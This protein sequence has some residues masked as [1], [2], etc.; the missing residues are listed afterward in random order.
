MKL[1]Q[2]KKDQLFVKEFL[3]RW[4]W[5]EVILVV[6]AAVVAY[7][8]LS[9]GEAEYT[10]WSK[11]LAANNV[12]AQSAGE[13]LRSVPE[14]S[15]DDIISGNSSA[16]AKLIVYIDFTCPFSAELFQTLKLAR[17]EHGD[18]LAI[19]WRMFPLAG[20][21]EA[22]PAARAF[23]CVAKQGYAYQMMEKL[24]AMQ[25]AG[26]FAP[27]L[28][29]QTA[30]NLGAK[31]QDYD[32]CITAKETAA[33]IMVQ[34]SEAEAAGVIGTPHTFTVYGNYPGALPME[35]FTDSLGVKRPGLKS[36]VDKLLE[37]K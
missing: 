9:G 6:A 13:P 32:E 23:I 28:Y 29:R 22:E 21:A 11:L 3:K 20:Q 19:A 34:K 12:G 24:F 37:N 26:E 30:L 27:A 7:Q 35:D 14:F 4:W 17:T 25:K 31:P 33:R 36:V 18:N 2:S 1:W 16:K 10:K 15:K 8:I 5:V